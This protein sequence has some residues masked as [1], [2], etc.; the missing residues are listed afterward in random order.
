MNA[1]SSFS[2]L[3]PQECVSTSAPVTAEPVTDKPTTRAPVTVEPTTS[4]P[5]T[6]EPTTKAPVTDKP[7]TKAPVTPAP[8]VFV[9]ANPQHV[10]TLGANPQTMENKCAA[11]DSNAEYTY[12]ACSG[13]LKPVK[14]P[15]SCK[16]VCVSDAFDHVNPMISLSAQLGLTQTVTQYDGETASIEFM[17]LDFSASDDNAFTSLRTSAVTYTDN[18]RIT[19]SQPRPT[20]ISQT[21][22]TTEVFGDRAELRVTFQLLSADG[23]S[24]TDRNG[25]SVRM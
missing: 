23:R 9:C 17:N 6:D 14:R 25:V 13:K 7:T 18:E 10:C 21:L 15:R 8:V 4:A 1:L 22:M 12:G 20:Q 24:R 5:V 16:N 2:A 19:R 11:D 3:C